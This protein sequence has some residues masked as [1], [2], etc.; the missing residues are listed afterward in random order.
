MKVKKFFL[1]IAQN[2]WYYVSLCCCLPIHLPHSMDIVIHRL[3][4]C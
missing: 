3:S 2:N 1:H 4:R